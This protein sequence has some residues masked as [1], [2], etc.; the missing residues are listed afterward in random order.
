M[1]VE[2]GSK[3]QEDV[4]KTMCKIEFEKTLHFVLTIRKATKCLEIRCG[5]VELK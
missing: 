1:D 4:R 3:G 2:R 5:V